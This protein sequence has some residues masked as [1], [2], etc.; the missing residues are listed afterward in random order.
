MRFFFGIASE[1]DK[2]KVLDSD[3]SDAMLKHQWEHYEDLRQTQPPPDHQKIYSRLHSF[4]KSE[5]KNA[6]QPFLSPALYKWYSVAATI[7]LLAGIGI[8]IFTDALTF[9]EQPVR[10]IVQRTGKAQQIHLELAD[11]TEVWL[12]GESRLT[13]PEK[14]TAS[15]LREVSLS[16][17]AFFEV[18][19]SEEKPFVVQTRNLEVQ[20]TGTAFNV[21]DYEDES[22]AQTV[23]MEGTVNVSNPGTKKSESFQT[24]LTQNEMV[25]YLP[26]KNTFGK[27]Y[28]NARQH[29]SWREGKLIFDNAPLEEVIL[30][31]EHWYGMDFH[32]EKSLK[33]ENRYTMTLEG[34]P[35]EEALR[36]LKMTTKMKYNIQGNDIYLNKKK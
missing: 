33:K 28:V 10:Q 27:K 15:G 3:E 17:E 35:I 36:I 4:I 13:Y 7:I 23:L 16:G 12:N 11:G 20:A 8:L 34:D 32:A 14:F 21:M 6:A 18:Q 1:E 22:I 24:V 30:R 5:E 9:G 25:T 19:A 31:L 26:E 29:S 2:R